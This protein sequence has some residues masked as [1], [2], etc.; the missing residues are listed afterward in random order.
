MATVVLT[1]EQYLAATEPFLAE[2][3]VILT[4][5][6]ANIAALSPEQLLALRNFN[7]DTI[8]ATDEALVL[9]IDQFVSLG[10]VALT[11][12]D[13]VTVRDTAAVL[14][15]GS[16]DDVAALS[17]ANVDIL[18]A[19]DGALTFSLDQ[20]AALGDVVFSEEDVVTIQGSSDAFAGGTPEQVAG[21]EAKNVDVVD[22]TDDVL[23]YSLAQFNALGVVSVTAADTVVVTGTGAELGALT[24]DQIA[25]LAADGVDILDA[26]DNAVT[27][28]GVQ[29]A[30]LLGTNIA[31]GAD[32][33]V[34]VSDTGAAL[35][36]LSPEQIAALT[37][38]GVD[39]FDATDDAVTLSVAQ[40]AAF[41]GGLSNTDAVTIFDTSTNIAALTAEQIATFVAQGVVSFDATDDAVT[42]SLAQFA[43]FGGTLSNTDAVTISD[44][45][46]NIAALTPAQISALTAQGVVA[47]DTSD[48][49]VSLSL[50]QL[51]AF[52][53][54]LSNTDAVTISDT[55]TNIAALTAAQIAALTGQ[56]VVRIDATDD[57]L[58]LSRDQLNALGS[59][60]LTQG[61]VVS[62][63]DTGAA[64]ASL[65]QAELAAF[66]AAG[67]DALDA[68]DNVVTVS[69]G[70]ALLVSGSALSFAANDVVTVSDTGAALSALSAAEIVALG[71]DGV[72][73]IDASDGAVSLTADQAA[74]LADSGISLAAGD[75]VAL[76]DTGAALGGLSAA[77]L[78]AL[79]GRGIDRIDAS[80][81]VLALSLAQLNALGSVGLTAG[82]T[83]TLRD[84]GGALSSLSPDQIGA[85]APRGID[86]LDATDN[87]ASLSLAQYSALGSL[88]F[89]AEDT[90][91]ITGTSGSDRIVGR[92]SND[93]I[94]GGRGHD[95]LYGGDG[96]DFL[97]GSSGN[98]R[99]YGGDGADFLKGGSG[100][101]RLYGQD[102][103]D[104]LYGGSGN[105]IMSGG[106]GRDTFVFDAKPHKRMN[107]DK[108]T[109]FNVKYDTIYLDNKVFKKL[110][111]GSEFKPGKL[112]SS[113]FERDSSADDRNDYLIYNKKN[114]V[115]YYDAD[116][117]GSGRAVEI[118]RLDKNL[119]L[120]NKDFFI[121]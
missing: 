44:T 73:V 41:G 21:L 114:G 113:Y 11:D 112:K 94:D 84:S 16:P 17:A 19:S 75:D 104:W 69:V 81:D 34:T 47:F 2:D 25:A 9:S 58:N 91:K 53:G 67:V 23:I 101:D 80:D 106:K 99:L 10:P 62:V 7:V 51:A 18:D 37:A 36:A 121:V 31:F 60:A 88:Q 72:D 5:T 95:R 49:A 56:G 74:A 110:G 107:L 108:I 120:T 24:A 89:A 54:R 15:S 3:D 119:K 46:A 116:G 90:L 93:I 115:L 100:N 28:A 66:A 111:K 32:D 63:S 92:S 97:N 105:D 71:A 68:T 98:D 83:I 57:V 13:T 109:D 50:A 27:L 103:N 65:T 43:A 82:D 76:A 38:K 12:A 64:I 86:A 61:D 77:E 52:G 33:A 102:G 22:A 14:Q 70:Q 1:V 96:A 78:A 48:N 26:S 6:G 85:L 4:D 87:F 20:F 8:D 35:S 30:A 39:A 117:S 42:L 59:I 118:A 79:N 29:A 55:S 40:F 45:S